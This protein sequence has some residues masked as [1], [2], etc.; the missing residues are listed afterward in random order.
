MNKVEKNTLFNE[1]YV[2]GLN[3]LKSS[4]N[5]ANKQFEKALEIAEDINDKEKQLLCLISLATNN[6]HQEFFKEAAQYIQRASIIAEVIPIQNNFWFNIHIQNAIANEGLKNFDKAIEHFEKAINVAEE[7]GDK[8]LTFVCQNSISLIYVQLKQYWKAIAHLEAALKISEETGNRDNILSCSYGLGI[9]YNYQF[10]YHKA[11]KYLERALP[12]KREIGDKMGEA[13]CYLSLSFAYNNLSNYQKAIQYLERALPLK[14]EIGDK[15][16]ESNCYLQ[17]GIAYKAKLDYEMATEY[18][19]KSLKL[20]TEIGDKMGEAESYANLG[21]VYFNLSDYQKAIMHLEKA[22]EVSEVINNKYEKSACYAN[23]GLVYFNLSDYQKAIMYF[24][25]ALPLKREIGDKKGEAACYGN[26]GHFH[27]YLLEHGKAMKYYEKTL[28]ISK[29]IGDKNI[30][31]Y[32]YLSMGNSCLNHRNPKPLKALSY[33]ASGLKVAKEIKNNKAN[34]IF[35]FSLGKCYSIVEEWDKAIAQFQKSLEIAKQIDD[36]ATRV[37]SESS[38]GICF[39]ESG[40]Y[41]KAIAQFQKSLELAKQIGE[42]GR[43]SL[44]LGYLGISFFQ[45]E[46]FESS[47]SHLK[48]AI[49]INEQIG[50]EILDDEYK[51][52]YYGNNTAVYRYMIRVCMRLNKFIEAYEYVRRSKAKALLDLLTTGNIKPATKNSLIE[53]YIKKERTLLNKKRII[54]NQYLHRDHSVDSFTGFLQIKAN[55]SYEELVKVNRSLDKLYDELEELDPRYTLLRRPKNISLNELQESVETFDTV[56]VDYYLDEEQVYIFV[57]SKERFFSKTVKIDKKFDEYINNCFVE[58]INYDKAVD[59]N[60]SFS[61]KWKDLKQYL[62]EPIEEYLR[63]MK[64]IYFIPHNIIHY[65]PLHALE[66]SKEPL[67]KKFGVLYL[68]NVTLL[69]FFR[70]NLQ[71]IQTCTAIGQF[72]GNEKDFFYREAKEVARI[73]NSTALIDPPKS[74]LMKF[75]KSDL[76]HFA[77]HGQYDREN[78]LN[79]QISLNDTEK[80]TVKEIFGLELNANLVTLSACESGFN[81][82]K[83]GDELIG[84]TRALTYAG[85]RSIIVSL[86]RVSDQSTYELMLSFYRN[87]KK[88]M[89]KVSALQTAQIRLIDDGFHSHFWAP[90]ILI[91]SWK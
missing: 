20:K 39:A 89:D 80:F 48:Q 14:R 28:E 76:L 29:I 87:L 33:I 24:E 64:F 58:V 74:E 8:N 51:I 7:I 30:E 3:F 43:I 26:L 6:N 37:H 23:L 62:L 31:M 90:F 34:M 82:Y 19:K 72:K 78:P 41:A 15:I 49:L 17:F 54:Q 91:G 32:A 25:R 11:I 61:N 46:Q 42:T 45:Q 71:E 16:G 66:L 75:I 53:E 5:E 57:F 50:K 22:L 63:D 13:E 52:L 83:V 77:T 35:H 55:S 44:I 81:K 67:I 12:L 38:I 65:I 60:N 88:G 68:Q 40:Q 36:L 4:M 1:Y 85:A 27:E 9:M 10:E 69:G 59:N 21:L 70:N 86:W 56:I 18:L 84:L 79:S 73:F 2:K 47:Y